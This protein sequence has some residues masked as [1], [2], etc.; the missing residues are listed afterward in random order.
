[1]REVYARV[2]QIARQHLYQFMKDNQISPLDYHFDYYFDTCIEVYNIKILEHHFSNLK[3]E[4]LT[5]IDAEGISFSYEKDNPIVKQNF[6]KCHELGHFILGH[7]GN[8]FTELSRSS[9]SRVETE[10]NLFSAAILM[11]DIV[12]LSNIY[13]RHAKFSQVESH[14]GVSAEALVYRLRDIFKFYLR[15]E[16]Q[17]INQAISAYQHN[18]N[19]YIIELFK[20]VKDEMET[21]YRSIEAN[22]FVAILSAIEENHFVSS[23]EF[24]DLIE[25]D[26][27]KDLEQLDTNIETCA[28]FDF[29]KTIGYAWNKEKI[30]KKQAQSRARTILLLETR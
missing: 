14:L 11:P 29:G 26:F 28:Y 20:L 13:Y 4:G 9:E 17:E 8:M 24:L 15:I 12:L 27:R 7:G 23:N 10:A 3:I 21:E 22:P 25:N 1:M 2:T 30:T 6:T 16:Y 18:N 19:K 5:M